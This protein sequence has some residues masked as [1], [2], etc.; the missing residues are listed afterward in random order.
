MLLAEAVGVE[1]FR[2]RVKIY[3]TDID[4]HALNQ[5]RHAVYTS[6]EV[7]SVPARL[8]LKYFEPNGDRFVFSK[9]L[10][11]AVIFGRNDLV[12]DAP[13]SRIDL[14]VCRNTLMYFNADT[15]RKILGRLHFAL[16]S[17]GFLSR[18]CGDAVE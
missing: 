14:L 15:Q 10:R 13:I 6:A 12:Q 3:A 11:R 8:R 9:D 16:A 2:H 7:E 5:A 17:H 18:P 4:E 1:S